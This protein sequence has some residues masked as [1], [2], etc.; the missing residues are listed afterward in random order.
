MVCDFLVLV[1]LLTCSQNVG[2]TA[3][4]LTPRAGRGSFTN[5][6]ISH[7]LSGSR[8]VL[9]LKRNKQAELREKL[10]KARQ[11]NGKDEVVSSG[12][13]KLSDS[14][15]KQQNDRK[16]FQQLLDSQGGMVMNDYASDGYLN[17]KQEEDEIQAARAGV[18][19]I[20]EGDPA[21]TDCF[22]N[23]VSIETCESIGTIGMELVLPWKSSSTKKQQDFVIIVTDPRKQSDEFRDTIRNLKR[24]LPADLWG[25]TMFISA[26]SPAEIKRFLKKNELE[27]KVE[28]F[29]DESL[30][31][32]REFTALGEKR[33]SMS[34]FVLADGRVQKLVRDLDFYSSAKVV[35]KAIESMKEARI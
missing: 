24:D 30:G 6:Y 20:F 29:A 25:K 17:A 33:L 26:D 28:I 34:V 13:K 8:A 15:I 35:R 10:A 1:A 12:N 16:R 4:L 18:N 31:F 7:Q 32:M 21:P 9:F 27:G 22:K 3:F 2:T 5:S 19:R 23:L 11:Q 14:E